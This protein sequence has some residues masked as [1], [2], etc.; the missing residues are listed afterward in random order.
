MPPIGRRNDDNDVDASIDER[1]I[2]RLHGFQQQ[3]DV[4]VLNALK[5]ICQ[6]R[7]QTGTSTSFDVVDADLQLFLRYG[8]CSFICIISRLTKYFNGEHHIEEIMYIE[9]VSRS[10]L[11]RIIDTFSHVLVSFER[12]DNLLCCAK[13][14][15]STHRNCLS[16]MN[17]I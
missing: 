6:N 12:Q 2:A 7:L 9:N 15:R 5:R 14:F 4:D 3:F 16:S 8:Y 10:M 13:V 17:S 1:I 11:H